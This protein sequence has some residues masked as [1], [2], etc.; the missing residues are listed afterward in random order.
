M[1][2][3]DPAEGVTLLSHVASSVIPLLFRFNFPQN[4]SSGFSTCC[5]LQH[6][7]NFA[8]L[9]DNQGLSYFQE[10]LW[11]ECKNS[12]WA[13]IALARGSATISRMKEKVLTILHLHLSLTR[14]VRP[15]KDMNLGTHFFLVVPF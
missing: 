12:R 13:E 14:E 8:Q 15:A 4:C 1:S 7:P 6:R 5:R 3:K 10:L 2:K 9:R 11:P